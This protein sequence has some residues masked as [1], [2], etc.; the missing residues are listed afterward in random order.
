MSTRKTMSARKTRMPTRPH[1]EFRDGVTLPRARKKA[2]GPRVQLT[3]VEVR[4]GA[5]LRLRIAVADDALAE[6]SDELGALIRKIAPSTR[7]A[8]V[9]PPPEVIAA[10]EAI[11]AVE[12]EF[13]IS[14][15]HDGDD[16]TYH[17]H[18]RTHLTELI[19]SLCDTAL[20]DALAIAREE[21][22]RRAEG[23]N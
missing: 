21:S 20:S 12:S 15:K 13:V 11:A 2:R 3:H 10:P 4:R 5:T 16:V 9:V 7:A 19:S 18:L 22:A 23:G 17:E 1:D 8:I 6:A 14:R